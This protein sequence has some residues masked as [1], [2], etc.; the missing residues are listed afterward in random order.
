MMKRT[1]NIIH[2]IL[3]AGAFLFS[4]TAALPLTTSAAEAWESLPVWDGTADAAW[5]AADSTELHINTPE[6]LAGLSKLSEMGITFAGQTIYLDADFCMNSAEDYEKWEDK[7][8]TNVWTPIENFQGEL[9]GNGSTIYNLYCNEPE[10]ESGLIVNL[11]DGGVSGVT[12]EN[13]WIES[14]AYAFGGIAAKA[15]NSD[16]QNCRVSGLINSKGGGG[17]IVGDASGGSIVGCANYAAI[18]G[19]GVAGIVGSV[20]GSYVQACYNRGAVTGLN[21]AGIACFTVKDE[22]GFSANLYSC[23]NTGAI[24]STSTNYPPAGVVFMSADTDEISMCYYLEG[25]AD[26]GITETLGTDNTTMV[27]AATLQS[28]SFAALSLSGYVYKEGDYPIL[29]WEATT[30]VWV[31]GQHF[32][33]GVTTIDCGSG[34]A[35]YDAA[36]DTLYLD[37]AAITSETVVSGLSYGIYSASDI[38]I[39]NRGV[40]TICINDGYI[41]VAIAVYGNLTLDGTPDDT[42]MITSDLEGSYGFTAEGVSVLGGNYVAA[43][44]SSVFIP[45]VDDAT[46]DISNYDG[47]AAVSTNA[48][49][50]GYTLWNGTTSMSTYKYLYLQERKEANPIISELRARVAQPVVGMTP[51]ECASYT[52]LTDNTTI[53]EITWQ[54]LNP[55]DEGWYIMDEDAKFEAGVEYLCDVEFVPLE[56]FSFVSARDDMKCYVNGEETICSP[57]YSTEKVYVYFY[58]EPLEMGDVT[59]DGKFTV[60]DVAALQKWLL[61]TPNAGVVEWR[62]GDFTGDKKL[63]GFDLAIMKRELLNQ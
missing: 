10:D 63:D 27:T 9:I 51:A 32:G 41:S 53:N 43:C 21:A 47:V 16:I 38:K 52:C 42:L 13:L 50:D 55:T 54:Y 25:S 18:T 15:E 11:T 6:E 45:R 24:K 17:G 31:N 57:V 22:N 30:D 62:A 20:T 23:Y 34:K 37:N 48:N 56:G 5:Y 4:M 29:S 44:A 46:F 58:A 26:A 28:N 40:S 14:G 7:A 12:L 36:S 33:N 35:T 8:P 61:N 49:G 59:A 2:T 1:W 60:S 19:S 3:T 39:V